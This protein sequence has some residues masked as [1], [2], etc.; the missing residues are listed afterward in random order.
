ML[1]FVAQNHRKE[2]LITDLYHTGHVLVFLS[3]CVG[4]GLQQDT[5]LN[6]VVERQALSSLRVVS[7]DD[8]L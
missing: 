4:D 7:H 3:E 8:Q 5:R 1:G 6:E 2:L